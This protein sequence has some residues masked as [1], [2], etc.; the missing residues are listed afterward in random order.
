MTD[1]TP[2]LLPCPFCG[3]DAEQPSPESPH[4]GMINCQS[5][6]AE[7]F[8]PKWNTRTTTPAPNAG[9]VK[10]K[11]LMGPR[12]HIC[13]TPDGV[14]KE[15]QEVV[16]LIRA[17]DLAAIETTPDPRDAVIARLVE[18]ASLVS[19]WDEWAFQ[20]GG[21][22]PDRLVNCMGKLRA[23]LAAAKEVMK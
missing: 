17:S 16:G 19:D 7:A 21:V 23:A 15:Q 8:G 20:V 22:C 6:G 4:G 14:P 18:A 2:A 3:G 5:C 9:A 12:T 11:P 1:P 10:V 13:W